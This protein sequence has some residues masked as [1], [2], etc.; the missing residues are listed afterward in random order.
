MAAQPAGVSTTPPSLVS[1]NTVLLIAAR[2][3]TEI[4]SC[5]R[6]LSLSP[7]SASPAVKNDHFKDKNWQ[8]FNL[9]A[10]LLSFPLL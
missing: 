1:S 6:E 9:H 2:G 7:N 8:A 3:N 10:A 5:I 4:I